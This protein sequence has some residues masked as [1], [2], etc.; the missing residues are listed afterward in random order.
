[1]FQGFGD[2]PLHGECIGFDS[3]AVHKN[4]ELVELV[5]Y[6]ALIRLRHRFES[7]TRYNDYQAVIIN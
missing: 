5:S 6:G 4:G 2:S 3:L 7:Y 1:M